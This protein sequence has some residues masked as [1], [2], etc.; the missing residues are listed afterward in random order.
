M[1]KKKEKNENFTDL[2]KK[3]FYY[4][5]Q[6]SICL[7]HVIRNISFVFLGLIFMGLK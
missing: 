2:K 6:K 3:F 7:S 5:C 4:F 1:S